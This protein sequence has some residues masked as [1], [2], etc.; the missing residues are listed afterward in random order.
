MKKKLQLFFD[1]NNIKQTLLNATFVLFLLTLLS[2]LGIQLFSTYGYE[3]WPITEYL[4]NYHG[5]FVRRGLLG[6]ILFFFTKNFNLNIEWTIK[7]FSLVCLVA[8][9]TFFVRAFLKKGYSLYILPLCFFLGT[10]ILE[11]CFWTKRDHLVFLF[12]IAALWALNK[13]EKS[14]IKFL[15]INILIIIAI[16]IHE[17]SAFFILPI[18]F[19]LV[20]NEYRNKT[21]LQSITLSFVIL[22]PSI[23]AFLLTLYYHGDMKTAQTIWDSWV[24]VANLNPAKLSNFSHGAISS[25]GWTSKW[26]FKMHFV[27]NFFNQSMR[28]MAMFFWS[29]II[30]VVY[31]IVTNALLV[32][33]KN[34]SI[35]TNKDK[36]VLSSILV[37]QLL[38]LL[39]FFLILSCDLGRVIFYWTASSFAIFLLTPKEETENL[40]PS[41]FTEFIER[42]NKGLTNI[43]RPTKTTV[44]LFMIIIGIPVVGFSFKGVVGSSV[45]YNILWILSRLLL[46]LK[47]IIFIF[48]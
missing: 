17:A 48:F 10:H 6:E 15:I 47:K 35:F 32:F 27:I 44:V 45:V 23:C 40:F 30:P 42:I 18:L 22:L 3:S 7:I 37:F 21:F 12:F 16:L 29:M 33:R 25:I 13:I 2:R 43:L 46:A 28:V 34:E 36:T 20:F 41:F 9:C 14:I 24:A 5:G 11:G 39:P 38:C 19:L 8:V 26:T 1:K 4:I 31:Y